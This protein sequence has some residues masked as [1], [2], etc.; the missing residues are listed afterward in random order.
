VLDVD[1]ADGVLDVGDEKVLVAPDVEHHA[2]IPEEIS[3][4][5]VFS[6]RD[7]ERLHHDDPMERAA[8]RDR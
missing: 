1:P 5:E 2:S 8:G 4:A 7:R 6:E 3:M